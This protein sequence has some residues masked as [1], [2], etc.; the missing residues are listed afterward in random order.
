MVARLAM[1]KATA[2][3]SPGAGSRIVLGADT[4]VV[5]DG[6][7][8]GKPA[9]ADDAMDTLLALSGRSH[10]VMSGYALVADAGETLAAGTVTTVVHMREISAA[11]AAAYA[12]TGEPMGKAGAYAIQGDGG[13]FVELVEGSFTNVMGLPLEAVEQELRAA[14][15]TPTGS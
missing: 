13:R 10:E 9:D 2:V 5:L 1:A 15:L 7:S 4:T 6:M 11:E 14:G 8:L 3:A 12:A